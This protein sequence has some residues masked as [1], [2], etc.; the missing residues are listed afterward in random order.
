[1]SLTTI[2]TAH[3][4]AAL[5]ALL[6]L[7]HGMGYLF[8]H[9][10]QPRVIGEILGGLLLGPT[11]LGHFLPD[12]HGSIF[13]S[14]DGVT[15]PVLG[16]VYQLGL[17]L[18]MFCSG[19][20][21]H[22]S[23]EKGERKTAILTA[24]TGTVVPFILGLLLLEAG[25]LDGASFLD[26]SRFL[27]EADND[28]A[29]LLVFA[30][31]IAVTSIPVISRIMFDLGLLET[32]FARIV[33][34]AA[35]I[36]DIILYIVLAMALG[37]VGG[38]SE[39]AFGLQAML[40]LGGQGGGA[41]AYH[42]VAPL[43]FIGISLVVG[44][45]L[46]DRVRAFRYNL[47]A[48]S[49]PIAFLLVFMLLM[50]GICVFLGVTPMFGAFVAGMVVSSRTEDLSTAREAIKQF[51]FAFFIPVY[52]AIV[53]LKLNL[54]KEFEILYFLFFLTFACAA[55]AVSVYF[56]ARF[57]GESRP[58]AINL[59][60]AMNARGGPGIVLASVAYDHA[61]INESFYAKLVMV[62]VVTSLL[63]GSW[64]ERVVR[65]GKPLR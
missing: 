63:A 9:Y 45:S 28:T 44:P 34:G 48:R 22:S 52:F 50:T 33:L 58:G 57:A 2:Q 41:K 15:G 56:G 61:I 36:E 21:I 24:G 5:A 20:E 40:G 32:S 62:A 17:L 39:D 7:A 37:M 13:P 54:A 8:S 19:L 60:V 1:M 14:W 27:G 49:S 47:L 53:G 26:T 10:R 64:L 31:A 43:A 12:V 23:F 3:V 25:R 55:K 65:A 11:V 59:A 38:G 46:F 6:V 18:L 35:V 51:S 16:A 29:F 30:I 42:V 4:L